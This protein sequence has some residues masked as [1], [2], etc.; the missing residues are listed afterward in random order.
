MDC[1]YN[2]GRAIGIAFQIKDD[3]LDS[4][5]NPQTQDR[6]NLVLMHYLDEATKQGRTSE[7]LQKKEN[8]MELAEVRE[9]AIEFALK[10]SRE[11]VER[12]NQQLKGMR[13]ANKRVLLEDFA[14]YSLER[15]V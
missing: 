5:G 11:H 6:V 12:A 10:K 13:D 1:L 7:I 4:P 2:Y 8:S 3:I 15:K 9:K 14:D